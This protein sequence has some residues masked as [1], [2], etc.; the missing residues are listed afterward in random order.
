MTAAPPFAHET[1]TRVV[2][3]RDPVARIVELAD[4]EFVGII[5]QSDGVVTA[6]ARIGNTA[7]VVFATDPRTQGGALGLEG[8]SAIVNAYEIALA[9]DQP[10]IGI[11]HSG[12]ARLAEGAR[13][14]HGVGLVFAAMT[15]ASGIV[16]QISVVLGAA[17]GGAAYGPA[18]TD[19]VIL[20]PTARMFVTGPDIVNRVTGESVDA[21]ELGGPNVHTRKSGLAHICAASDADAYARARDIVRTLR[22]TGQPAHLASAFESAPQ[23]HVPNNPRRA[24]DMRPLVNEVLDAPL[25]EF[26]AQ[27]APNIVT[28]LGQIEGRSVGVIANNP[29]RLGGCLNSEAS[30]KAAR[31]VRF[32][33]SFGI[34]LVVFVDVPGYLPGGKQE[35]SGIIRRGAKLL[36]AFAACSVPRFTVIVGKAYGGA[37]IAMNSRSLGATEV[38]AWPRATVD[39]MSAEAAVE[40]TR[41]RDLAEV[42][43]EQRSEAVASFAHDHEQTTGGLSRAVA[44]GV[45]DRVI[46]PGDTRAALSYGLQMTYP[47]RSGQKNIPL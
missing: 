13:S 11:W 4:S 16:P 29:L 9:A 18:L 38:V 34:P 25:I 33:D 45:V 19:V 35:S 32:C 21:E 46:Q 26:H 8:C 1:T 5:D 3:L 40:I 10:I 17:A 22:P 14:L 43:P 42:A 15:R 30:E 31:F 7:C 2:D 47:Y 20:S 36:H 6:R 39:V 44:E 27:W 37:Y 41:R 23:K 24:Y 12:G 28:G